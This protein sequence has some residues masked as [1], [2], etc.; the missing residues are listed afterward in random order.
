MDGAFPN[1]P[2]RSFDS[3][4]RGPRGPGGLGGPGGGPGRGFRGTAENA[5][6]KR[7]VVVGISSSNSS[8]RSGVAWPECAGLPPLPDVINAA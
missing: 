4:G 8:N 7:D 5:K 3:A 1:E 6:V 2:G